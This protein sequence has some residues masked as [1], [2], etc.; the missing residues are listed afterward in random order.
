[1]IQAT[2]GDP[3]QWVDALLE[4][5]PQRALIPLL[6]KRVAGAP[7]AA[8]WSSLADAYWR[9]GRREEAL[10]AWSNAGALDPSDDEWS[11]KLDRAAAGVDPLDGGL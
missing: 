7:N 10:T 1:V 8:F 2:R 11:T 3:Q 6:E 9:D 5:A 4:H